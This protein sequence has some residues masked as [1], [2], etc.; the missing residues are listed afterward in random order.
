MASSWQDKLTVY[1]IDAKDNWYRI[2]GIES[3][4]NHSKSD[5]MT[6]QRRSSRVV[7]IR[8]R[9]LTGLTTRR[10]RECALTGDGSRRRKGTR[11]SGNGNR[12]CFDTALCTAP[13]CIWTNSY[14]GLP[15]SRGPRQAA[16]LIGDC[17]PRVDRP[18]VMSAKASC[19]KSNHTRRTICPSTHWPIIRVVSG[20]C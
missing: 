13:V 19:S 9:A 14:E 7:L 2:E 20:I 6:S 15:K 11:S 16:L 10:S 17:W 12:A 4:L 5:P 1:Q 8:R 18:A 3:R